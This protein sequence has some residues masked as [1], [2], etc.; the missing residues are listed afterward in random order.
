MFVST[1]MMT[2]WISYFTNVQHNGPNDLNTYFKLDFDWR[3]RV[4]VNWGGGS[5]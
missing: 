3:I 1:G 4:R 2:E 5:A